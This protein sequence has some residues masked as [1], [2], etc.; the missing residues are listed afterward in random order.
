MFSPPSRWNCSGRPIFVF[1]VLCSKNNAAKDRYFRSHNMETLVDFLAKDYVALFIIMGIGIQMGKLSI[2]GISFDSSAVVFVAMLYGYF[3]YSY[4]IPLVIPDIIQQVGLLLFIFTIG[5]QAGPLFFEA[6]K[7]KGLGLIGLGILPVVIGAAVAVTIGWIFEL[8]N[9]LMVGLFVGGLSST[10][11]LAAAIE[12]TGSP[13]ASIGYGIGYPFGVIGVILFIKL[14]PKIFKISLQKEEEKYRREMEVRRP[15]VINANF[16]ITNL[17]VH[18]RSI[19][20]L[21]IRSATQATISRIMRSDGASETPTPETLLYQ[22]DII[23]AVG[24]P[25]ALEKLSL[26]L[27]PS[28]DAEIPSS[29]QYEVKWYTVSKR[30]AVNKTLREL[31]LK[32]NF[33]ATV[34]RVRRAGIDLPAEPRLRLRFGDRLMIS[35]NIDN[36]EHLTQLLGDSLK[37]V[38][39]TSFLPVAIGIVIGLIVGNLRLPLLFNVSISLGL[40]G[41]VLIAALVLSRIGKTGPIIWN[42]PVTGNQILRQF[43]LLLFL[44][45]VGLTA[46][47]LIVPVIQ[48]YGFS[49]FAMA[50][51]ITLVPMMGFMFIGHFFMKINFLSLLGALAGGMTSTPGLSAVDS[52]TPTAAPQVAYATVYPFAL[53]AIVVCTQILASL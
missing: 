29:E 42:L 14:S 13:A 22:G 25:E 50:A 32:K 41:G 15:K 26:L 43:G 37:E 48:D 38:E 31:G 3:C 21:N 1:Q 36:E 47:A 23:K 2:K 30:H 39:T 40:T 19:K 52:M 9:D 20:D 6:L 28:C 12:A 16:I 45:P 46:G 10:P 35:S 51:V 34:T 4:G 33:K 18:Q 11:G 8:D 24:T 27:G 5:M 53:V 44:A 17:D 7:S 49:L